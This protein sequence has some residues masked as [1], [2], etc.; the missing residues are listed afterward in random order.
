MT[1][2]QA[3]NACEEMA[4]GEYPYLPFLI[5]IYLY[6]SKIVLILTLKMFANVE[7]SIVSLQGPSTWLRKNCSAEIT[8]E[9]I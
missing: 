8:V 5:F 2:M 1:L 3:M 4:Y 6:K 7:P 9:F